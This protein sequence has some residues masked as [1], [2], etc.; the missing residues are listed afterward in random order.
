MD[1]SITI[2]RLVLIDALTVK[3]AEL[4]LEWDAEIKTLTDQRDA[5][6]VTK[7]ALKDWYV[8]V[9]AMLV[10]GE[11]T[12]NAKGEFRAVDE[13]VKP[14]PDKPTVSNARNEKQQIGYDITHATEGKREQLDNLDTS[15]RLLALATNVTVEVGTSQYERLLNQGVNNASRY[16]R[17]TAR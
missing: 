13:D 3:R 7:L 11:A 14:V 1:L 6:P 5:L 8:A 12:L 2:P 4:A 16:Y 17:H 9:T 15:L 10:A